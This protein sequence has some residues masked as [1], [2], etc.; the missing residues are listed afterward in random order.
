MV[1]G[2]DKSFNNIYQYSKNE[3]IKM[4]YKERFDSSKQNVID[5]LFIKNIDKKYLKDAAKA[6]NLPT[7]EQAIILATSFAD[8]IANPE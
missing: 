8:F 2:L 3:R 7:K 6:D 1:K 5:F 4:F